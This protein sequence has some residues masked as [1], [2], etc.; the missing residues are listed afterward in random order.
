MGRREH[1]GDE[2]GDGSERAKRKF[3][4]GMDV[5]TVFMGLMM[6]GCMYMSKLTRSYILNMCKCMSIELF[7]KKKLA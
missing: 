1:E 7:L 3:G 2:G 4:E 6:H 5:V